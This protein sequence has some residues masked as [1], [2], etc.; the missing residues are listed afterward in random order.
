MILAFL[1]ISP[2]VYCPPVEQPTPAWERRFNHFVD[3]AKTVVKQQE[4]KEFKRFVEAIGQKESSGQQEAINDV[5]A[6]GKYQFTPNT[7]RRLGYDINI[8]RFINSPKEEFSLKMQEEAMMKLLKFNRKI[9]Q[10]YI[11]KYA[12]EVLDNGVFVTESGILA[13]AHLGGAFGV[14]KYLETGGV[15]NPCDMYGTSLTDYMKKF[16]GYKV[17]DFYEYKPYKE[18]S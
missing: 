5:G 16:S 17:S 2:F 11:D 10:D 18:R 1:L 3:A 4:R 14:Q 13:A 8:R 15:Y 6:M 7:L 9:L 12:G